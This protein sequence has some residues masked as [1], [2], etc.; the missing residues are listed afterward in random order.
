LARAEVRWHG[1]FYEPIEVAHLGAVLL[2]E[3]LHG[4]IARLQLL[5]DGWRHQI[6]IDVWLF[7]FLSRAHLMLRRHHI[8]AVWLHRIELLHWRYGW[9]EILLFSLWWVVGEG[10]LS[11][12]VLEHVH[13][14]YS[15]IL[16]LLLV[17][18]LWILLVES[19]LLKVVVDGE[20]LRRLEW[21]LHRLAVSCRRLLL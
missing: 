12:L 20:L 15:H 18:H 16:I 2:H 6:R 21:L 13:I 3:V 10:I 7:H 11:H 4:V 14:L 8:R 1:G 5:L 9:I 17:P 19:A